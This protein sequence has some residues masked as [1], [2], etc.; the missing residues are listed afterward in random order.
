MAKS[1]LVFILLFCFSSYAN[2]F[3]FVSGTELSDSGID[4]L[5]SKL[6]SLDMK[7]GPKFEETFNQLVKGIENAV[8]NEK[9]YCSGDSPNL[10]GK[11]LPSSQKQYCMRELKRKYTE[12]TKTIFDVKKKYLN[13]I[14]Q[15]QLQRLNEIQIKMQSEIDQ[16]F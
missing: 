9:I 10:K 7:D 8:E 5:I 15:K 4:T 14:Y 1:V 11:T 12:A 2:I 6:N 16:T 13:H 3:D